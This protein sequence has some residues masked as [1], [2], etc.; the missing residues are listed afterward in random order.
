MRNVYS[1]LPCEVI[2][3]DYSVPSVDCKPMV[4]DLDDEGNTI[5]IS[6][7]LDVPL[8]VLSANN[9]EAEITMPV[10]VGDKVAVL[11]SD[12]DTSNVMISNTQDQPVIFT[13]RKDMYPMMALC[14]FF[15]PARTGAIDA[16]NVVIKNKSSEII[17][18]KSGLIL[19]NDCQITPTGNVITKQGTNLDT[20]FAD[21]TS[22]KASHK[23]TGVERG[24]GT[25]DVPTM[26]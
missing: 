1:I 24:S 17:M 14:G 5:K 19:A 7:I 22:F 16:E 9:G 23:H 10:V 26:E 3:I 18:K 8:F 6:N 11:L 12:A 25:T 15:T 13:K 20:F 4:Y 2:A 21:Y